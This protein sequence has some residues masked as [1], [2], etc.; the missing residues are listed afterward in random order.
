MFRISFNFHSRLSD[1]RSRGRPV[2]DA[3]FRRKLDTSDT[4]RH[5]C[6]F[7]SELYQAIRQLGG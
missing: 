6:G 5:M 2:S 4:L 7:D 3:T 1:G